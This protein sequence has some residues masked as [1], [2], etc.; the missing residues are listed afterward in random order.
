[1]GVLALVLVLCVVQL[2]WLYK[3]FKS[4]GFLA[5][6]NLMGYT[7]VNGLAWVLLDSMK[8]PH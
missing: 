4:G 2:V 3:A 8:A 6:I 7:F 1:M 5:V